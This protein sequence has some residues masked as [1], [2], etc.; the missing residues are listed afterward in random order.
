M[1]LSPRVNRFNWARAPRD[2]TVI[3]TMKTFSPLL[4]ATAISCAAAASPPAGSPEDPVRAY[5]RASDTASSAQLR[6]AFHPAAHL[7]SVGVDG[8]AALVTQLAWWQRLDAVTDAEP[9]L[10][11]RIVVLDREGP[12]ALVEAVSTW[13]THVFDDLLLVARTP[14]GWRIVGKAFEKL[15]PGAS[16]GAAVGDDEAIRAV[17]ADK[18]AAHAAYDPAL[19]ARSHTP[20]CLYVSIG[21]DGP[22]T[23]RTLSEA[24]ARYARLREAGEHGRDSRWRVLDVIVRDRIAAVKLDVIWQG[25][26]YVD[27]L[28]LLRL[29]EGWR[30]AAAQWGDP[31]YR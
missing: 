14:D 9:A 7:L 28:L 27:H 2:G 5:F 3:G 31:D 22:M 15:A 25:R 4:C 16:A 13:K 30:I 12:L 8:Q 6:A 26:R 20:M 19:L 18:I 29:A 1:V 24:A 23:I 21:V 17:I 11:R 10:E